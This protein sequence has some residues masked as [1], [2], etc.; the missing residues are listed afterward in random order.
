MARPLRIQYEG[1]L[2]HITSRGNAGAKIF[3]TDSDRL[4]FLDVLNRVVS[5]YGWICHAYC[6]MSNHYH[7]LIETLSP[8]LSK[9][10]QLLNGVYTQRFNRA[11]K[12]IGTC[13]RGTVQGHPR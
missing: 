5:R 6:L 3:E 1:A 10:M 4:E 9:G 13:F 8:N 12:S 2:Y 11:A 7:L